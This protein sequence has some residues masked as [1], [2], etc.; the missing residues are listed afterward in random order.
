MMLKTFISKKTYTEPQI[1]CKILKG[2]KLAENLYT[3]QAECAIIDSNDPPTIETDE[4]ALVVNR[5]LI[6][7]VGSWM[8]KLLFK[9]ARSSRGDSSSEMIKIIVIV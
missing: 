9:Q 8:R 2:E 3:V 7:R 1:A 5:L 6:T 4:F